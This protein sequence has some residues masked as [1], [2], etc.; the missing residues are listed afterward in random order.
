VV[1]VDHF[2]CFCFKQMCTTQKADPDSKSEYLATKGIG[3]EAVREEFPGATI[4]RPAN[5]MGPEDFFIS[6]LA[7]LATKVPGPFPIMQLGEQGVYHDVM[8]SP[9]SVRRLF[10]MALFPH[11]MPVLVCWVL[12][13]GCWVLSAGCWVLGAGCWVLGAG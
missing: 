12:G 2:E 7:H 6:R 11:L 4:I 1:K 8:K 9:V 13:A 10:P 5:L 3:E